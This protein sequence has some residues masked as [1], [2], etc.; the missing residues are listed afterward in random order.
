MLAVSLIRN[1]LDLANKKII[2]EEIEALGNISLIFFLSMSLMSLK[3]WQ[4]YELALPMLIILGLQVLMMVIF[5]YYLVFRIMGKDYDAAV[6]SSGACGFGLGAT[7]N[8]IANMEA[9][10]EKYKIKALRAFFIVPIVGS[11]FIDF[12]NAFSITLFMNWFK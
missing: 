8:A 7:A 6:M 2:H 4:L 5:S 3:L 9:L 10:T 11:L 1:L 12:F